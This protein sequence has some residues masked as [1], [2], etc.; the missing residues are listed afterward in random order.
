MPYIETM[1]HNYKTQKINIVKLKEYKMQ[2][3]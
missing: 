2:D 3:T 1:K